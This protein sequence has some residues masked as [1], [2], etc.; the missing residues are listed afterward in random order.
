M[1]V[2]E[3]LE[4]VKV[5][6]E[7][8]YKC[9]YEVTKKA[10]ESYCKY[11]NFEAYKYELIDK[12]KGYRLKNESNVWIAD[13]L[14]SIKSPINKLIEGEK[15]NKKTRGID[16]VNDILSDSTMVDENYEPYIKMFAMVYYSIG[17]M[18]PVKSNPLRLNDR[19]TWR[20]KLLVL[21]NYKK[22]SNINWEEQVL[23]NDREKLMFIRGNCLD[24]MI[25]EKYMPKPFFSGIEKS[26]QVFF[27]K[28]WTPLQK[29]LWFLNN[30]KLIIE[31]SHR[32]IHCSDEQFYGLNG[33]RTM[34]SITEIEYIFK[35][36]F[37]K[38]GIESNFD[39]SLY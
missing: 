19:D 36:I 8:G 5:D 27:S 13:I 20:N 17:N 18:L 29:K 38:I 24:D 26:N 35:R 28:Q 12:K 25:G 21:L 33:E 31:R 14:T 39:I 37:E 1:D 32:I 2:D 4:K 15:Y 23:L 34:K 3:F 7:V 9:E 10:M 11:P 22:E 30:A 6:R 16:I